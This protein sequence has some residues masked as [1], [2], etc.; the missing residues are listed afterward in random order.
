MSTVINSGSSLEVQN[1]SLTDTADVAIQ[2]TGDG[3][4]NNVLIKAREALK[5]IQVRSTDNGTEYL[6]IPAGQGLT[7]DINSRRTSPFGLV[8][9]RCASGICT[10]EVIVTYE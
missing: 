4:I 8:Y 10:A 2:A 7:I 6:T 9:I 1:H 3:K 5:E